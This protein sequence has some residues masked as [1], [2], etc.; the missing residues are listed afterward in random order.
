[1]VEVPAGLRPYTPTPHAE[2]VART[3]DWFKK[4]GDSE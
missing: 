2:A 4:Y 1:M 3:V